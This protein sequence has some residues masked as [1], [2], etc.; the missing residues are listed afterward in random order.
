MLSALIPSIHS[1]PAIHLVAKP[2]DQRY[3][4]PSPL[5]LRPTPLKY[6]TPVTDRDRPVSRRSEPS[7]R[8]FLIGEQP[9]AWELLHPRAKASRHRISHAVITNSVDYIITLPYKV[10]GWRVSRRTLPTTP[11]L[12]I[13]VSTGSIS[14]L[15]RRLPTGL[16]ILC[17][18][19]Y[20]DLE[21]SVISQFLSLL[22]FYYL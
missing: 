21:F 2:V 19:P 1:Y 10:R 16:S 4:Q 12:A 18:C 7:S 11:D 3:V 9:N 15:T 8:A 13:E 6:I 5:V 22:M 20:K 17:F 14:I